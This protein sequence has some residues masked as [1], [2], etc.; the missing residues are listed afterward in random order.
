VIKY[1]LQYINMSCI[2]GKWAYAVIEYDLTY[3]SLKSI[4]VH[5]VGD[6]IVEHQVGDTQV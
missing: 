1:M 4:K 5:V 6:F 3:K 2:I